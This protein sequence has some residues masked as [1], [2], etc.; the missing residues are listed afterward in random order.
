M[1]YTKTNDKNLGIV[2]YKE[3]DIRDIKASYKHVHDY[4]YQV[5][6]FAVCME[7]KYDDKS[8]QVIVLPILYFNYPTKVGYATVDAN[9]KTIK[10]YV[11][12]YEDSA[13]NIGN[14]LISQ[15]KNHFNKS[16]IRFYISCFNNIH[17]HP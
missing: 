2:F 3:K 10:E 6:Y 1:I 14:S 11:K 4:E 12:K 9:M 16:N 7:E 5:H 17:K 8:N 15:L 13:I